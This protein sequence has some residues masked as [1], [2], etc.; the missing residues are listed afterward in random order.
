M[1]NRPTATKEGK[2]IDEHI[3]Y[4]A[5][6][7]VIPI[8][9]ILIVICI[10]IVLSFNKSLEDQIKL[11]GRQSNRVDDISLQLGELKNTFASLNEKVTNLETLNLRRDRAE[12]IQPFQG[13][14][15]AISLW[16]TCLQILMRKA[17]IHLAQW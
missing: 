10:V 1:L 16:V 13:L 17:K 9:A 8:I 14:R 15:A 6:R 5:R 7:F 4:L 11:I 3:R 12:L 2:I